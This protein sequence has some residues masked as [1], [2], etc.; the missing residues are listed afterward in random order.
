MIKECHTPNKHLRVVILLSYLFHKVM[1][2]ERLRLLHGVKK[3][4]ERWNAVDGT[5]VV[6]NAF[7]SAS[8]V[9]HFDFG[10]EIND[11]IHPYKYCTQDFLA[12]LQYTICKG[13]HIASTNVGT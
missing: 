2:M 3:N 12:E 1:P 6:Y 10:I 11:Q 8:S 4:W 7:R 5:W 9:C 13:V